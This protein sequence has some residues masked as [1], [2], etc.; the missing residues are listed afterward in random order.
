ME[1]ASSGVTAK[2]P[3]GWLQ[4]PFRQQAA[5]RTAIG[6]TGDNSIQLMQANY[7]EL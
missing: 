2:Y 4:L 7:P 3:S 6:M 1:T 5:Y